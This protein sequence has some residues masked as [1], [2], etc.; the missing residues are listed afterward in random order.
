MRRRDDRP[1]SRSSTSS[2]RT[3]ARSSS[4]TSSRARCARATPR[5]EIRVRHQQTGDP[6]W[7]MCNVVLL[8]DLYGN[9]SGY[10]AIGRDLTE[11]KRTGGSA[12]RSEPPQGR[13]D[14]SAP[15]HRRLDAADHLV[16]WAGRPRRLLQP[17]LVRAGRLQSPAVGRCRADGSP[18]LHPDDSSAVERLCGWSRSG[19]GTPF[20]MEYRLKFPRGDDYRWYLGRALPLRDDVGRHRS[21]V[22]HEHRH[23]RS[24]DGGVGARR[25]PGASPRRA[26]C[27][28]HRDVPLGH[29][30]ERARLRQEPG[31]T[32]RS[33]IGR[34]RAIAPRVLPDGA[35]GRSGAG[36]RS[37]STVRRTGSRFRGGVPRRLAGR[38]G[39]LVVRQGQDRAGY[40]R[41]AADRWRARAST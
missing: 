40:G 2:T 32:A 26:G 18:A 15:P 27:L 30:D 31:S 17:P 33:R 23:P 39:P 25:E 21:L 6:M 24:Q 16:G 29:R 10:A 35:R 20:E 19:T 14:R 36:R 41:T 38:Y 4:A 11:R 8:R 1:A 37:L 12:A 5:T 22:R 9:P 34:F 13:V 3:I 7:M 28:G